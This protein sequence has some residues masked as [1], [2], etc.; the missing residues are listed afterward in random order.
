[1]VL[2]VIFDMDGVIIDSEAAYLDWITSYSEKRGYTISKEEL[3]RTIGLSSSMIADTF[4]RLLGKGIGEKFWYEFV[5]ESYTYPFDYQEA[6]NPGIRALLQTL[7]EHGIRIGLA[8]ASDRRDID[9]MLCA[10]RLGEYFDVILSGADFAESKPNPDIYVTAARKLG[11]L[12]VNCVVV[13]DSDYGIEAGKAAGATVIAIEDTR[14]GF[15]QR[16]ADY[17]IKDMCEVWG[18]LEDLF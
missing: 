2:A 7:R 17:L 14:F 6:L 9:A 1:M 10:N 12:P 15:D 8:S 13:E 16:K 5:E 11:V 18:I 4:D 3:Q